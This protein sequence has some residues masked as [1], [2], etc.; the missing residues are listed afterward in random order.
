[1]T[2]FMTGNN[3]VFKGDMTRRALICRIDPRC[4]HPDTRTFKRNLK[5]YL[6]AHRHELLSAALTILRAYHVAGRPKHGNA[7]YGSF[8]YWDALIRGALLWLGEPDPL[9]SRNRIETVD[10]EKSRFKRLLTAWVAVFGS[11]SVT[12]SALIKAATAG[13][14]DG[15]FGHEAKEELYQALLDVAGRGETINS[16]T[17]AWFLRKHCDGVVS[18]YRLSQ[19][20]GYSTRTLWC[21][22]FAV[23]AIS[24]VIPTQ[25]GKTVS[26]DKNK[27]NSDKNDSFI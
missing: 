9:E 4:E 16:R 8:E 1:V 2:L 13:V 14:G 20:G 10:P 25:R 19:V 6:L 22:T 21:V 11:E 7:P 18:N 3:I 17:L 15:S 12:V 27:V 24:A 26:V 23:S 5:E